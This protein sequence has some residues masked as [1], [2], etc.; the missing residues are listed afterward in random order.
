[1]GGNTESHI[2]NVGRMIDFVAHNAK[3]LSSSNP[4]P[5]TQDL[6]QREGR[7]IIR[8]RVDSI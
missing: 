8:D 3:W 1:M 5:Q 6:S 2:S 7:K 4:I